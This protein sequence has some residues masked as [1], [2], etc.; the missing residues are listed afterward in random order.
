M[1]IYVTFC[2]KYE[3]AQIP[4]K[5]TLSDLKFDGESK[6]ELLYIPNIQ[7]SEIIFYN[8]IAPYE[9]LKC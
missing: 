3:G 6:N 4:L 5:Y 1:P 2:I 9:M 8:I 7:I